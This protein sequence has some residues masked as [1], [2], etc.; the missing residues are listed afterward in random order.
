MRIR[1][2][3]P[4]YWTDSLMVSLPVMTRL[5]YIALWNLADDSGCILDEPE[6]IRLTLFAKEPNF[7]LE[8]HLDLLVACGRL[9]VYVG[10]DNK[11]YFRVSKWDD[12]QKPNRPG[13][14]KILKE[15][16]S[17][18]AIPNAARRAVATK[19]GC[20]PGEMEHQAFCYFCGAPGSILWF[21][22]FSGAPGAWVAFSGLELDHF[23]PEVKGGDTHGDNLILS[24]RSCNR[25]R[26]S[27]NALDFALSEWSKM[28][29]D[30]I[31][32]S[33]SNRIFSEPKTTP[34]ITEPNHNI[35][36]SQPDSVSPTSFSESRPKFKCGSGSVVLPGSGSGGG[37]GSDAKKK[38]PATTP[39]TS[40]QNDNSHVN[41][42]GAPNQPPISCDAFSD[43]EPHYPEPDEATLAELR[44]LP[45]EEPHP[46][47]D[48]D[49]P[50]PG[51]PGWQQKAAGAAASPVPAPG[52]S[53]T[54]IV[55]PVTGKPLQRSGVEKTVIPP[56]PPR[57]MTVVPVVLP[58]D[59]WALWAKARKAHS[60]P[61]PTRTKKQEAFL[62]DLMKAVTGTPR[63]MI[64]AVMGEYARDRDEFILK[65]G[66]S[67]EF[68][69]ERFDG[70]RKGIEDERKRESQYVYIPH[71]NG[72]MPP[73]LA[74]ID[75]IVEEVHAERRKQF[76]GTPLEGF[77]G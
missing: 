8:A 61:T 35:T 57:R 65:R 27:K 67:L 77:F 9:T 58:E 70:L 69:I 55:Q 37:S 71:Q 25:T 45:P 24:C 60:L 11:R 6:R 62:K 5:F 29:S 17:K 74:G 18:V 40:L 20:K 72:P 23:V 19:Y 49:A 47:D 56:A 63:E 22:L 76:K 66:H 75:R 54:Q 16:A 53:A 68:L 39:P 73:A 38:A 4:E 10:P 15:G 13:T 21:P 48:I 36:E 50:R 28:F 59:D 34:T 7:N 31:P 1:A 52:P 64:Y 32:F 44:K 12:H 3:K 43:D 46:M 41:G 33:E 26:Q 2:V 14:S 42:N 30:M 51:E